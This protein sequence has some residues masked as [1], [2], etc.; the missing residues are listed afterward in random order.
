M[1]PFLFLTHITSIKKTK[2]F[3]FDFCRN[4]FTVSAFSVLGCIRRLVQLAAFL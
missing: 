4:V 2:M 1:S 3:G